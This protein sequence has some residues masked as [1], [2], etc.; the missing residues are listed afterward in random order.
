MNILDC[1]LRD[2]GYYN[3]WDFSPEVVEAY[4][5]AVAAANID[6]VELGL[7]NFPKSEF[8]GAYAY[9]TEDHLNSLDLPHGPI[10]GVMVDA[11]TIL[12]SELTIEEAINV[13]FVPAEKSKISLVRVAAHFPEVESSGP[14][15]KHLKSLGYIVGYNLMQAGGKLD[16]VIADKARLASQWLELD[17]LYFADSLGNMDEVE[18][19]RVVAALRQEWNGP[20]GIHTHNNMG[21]GLDNTMFASGV[22]VTWLDATVT[23]MGRGA[24]NTQ[25]ENLLATLDIKGSQYNSNAI[26]DLVVRHFESMQKR[27]SWGT[28]LLYF[29][30]AQNGVHP[31]YIQNLLADS[32]YGTDELVGAITYLSELE[33]TE[34]Y[35]GDVLDAALN[36]N[37]QA[38]PVT[39]SDD[40]LD[41][42]KSREVLIVNN[43]P[44]LQKYLEGIKLYIKRRKPIVLAVNMIEQ[45]DEGLVDYY[46]VSH[47]TK[48]LSENL[49]YTDISTPIIFPKH[50]FKKEELGHFPIN[51]ID[52]GFTV[53]PNAFQADATFC[54][55]P[56][57]L[58]IAYAIAIAM[59]GN[60][61]KLSLVGV[62]GY[63]ATDSRQLEMLKLIEIIS[64]SNHEVELKALTP[65]C[66]PLA[67][68][69]IYA[70]AI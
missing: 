67:K 8:L 16:D 47:N 44:S 3:N 35:S 41:M 45:L 1:T 20:I 60:C 34:S 70:P 6:Y 63:E 11:K 64:A 38:K 37:A 19:E 24:G 33:G 12:E 39:G 18:V 26:Y 57:D 5:Y 51:N 21:K 52:Y 48:F 4:L 2:G 29:L 53:E 49:K 43:G 66:Y 23:G 68:G 50:R 28:N 27:Y 40:L 59:V 58:T 61:N 7:R 31:T 25:T 15:V 42:F 46:C 13:L 17:V 56:F 10:Y 22:G 9:T 36:I 65:T 32:H 54:I 69:S 62:D 30:G 14:I 55:A